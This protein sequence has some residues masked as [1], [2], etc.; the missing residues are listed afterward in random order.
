MESF[1]RVARAAV[2]EAGALL[3]A[4]WR[5]AQTIHYKGAV[6]IVTETD[7]QVEA[8]VGARLRAAF[9]DHLIVAEEASSGVALQPPPDDAY[10]WYLDPLDGTTNFAH[11]YPHFAVS[12]ALGR[13]TDL[14]LGIVHDP[15]RE[16]TFVGRRAGGAEL[17]GEPIRISPIDQLEH[18]LL[19]TGFPYDR[20]EH[21]DFYL[22]FAA[23]FMSAAQ[24]IR[25]NGSAALDLCYVACG[26]LDGFWE[27]KL[28][29]WDVAAGTLIVR[30]A[31]GAVSDFHGAAF[32][33]YGQ[34]TLASNGRVHG[35]MVD[36]LSARLR[37]TS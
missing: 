33:L 1:E 23:D 36:T 7:R 22:G 31:G 18:A 13:G 5:N 34:Q 15:L 6:D 17:N 2:D 11:A 37:R 27:W 12:L 28:H 35:A 32:D 10:V 21:R 20:R 4:T 16:E 25:R 19:G 3:R 29:P 8:L 14:L 24:G 30:E 26:R 9:P